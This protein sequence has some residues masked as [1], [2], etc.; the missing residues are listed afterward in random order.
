MLK[1]LVRSTAMQHAAGSLIASYLRLVHVTSSY[2]I[3]PP[4]LHDRLP[5]DLPA[6]IALWHGEHFMSWFINNGRYETDALISRHRDGEINAIAAQKLGSGTIRGSGAHNREF[7]R[8][9]AVSAFRQMVAALNSGRNI[10]MTADVPKVARVAGSG[11][12]KLA[13]HSGRPIIPMAIATSRRRQ[14]DTWDKSVVN[15][16]FSRIAIAAGQPI[17]V[18]ADADPRTLEEKR[19]TVENSLNATTARAYGLADTRT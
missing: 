19:R 4:D 9:G 11:I 6:I 15:L 16:P 18:D 17:W 12:I 3:D 2:V 7:Q 13:A 8:K 5:P 14:L 1:K 10:V